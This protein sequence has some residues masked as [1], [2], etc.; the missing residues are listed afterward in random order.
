VLS[1]VTSSVTP[2]R[3]LLCAVPSATSGISE[4]VWRSTKPGVTQHPTTHGEWVKIKKGNETIRAYLAYPERKTK[5]PA[6]I[7]IHEIFGLTEWAQHPASVLPHGHERRLELVVLELRAQD[8]PVP[9]R[10]IA[11]QLGVSLGTV[12]DIERGAGRWTKRPKKAEG[13]SPE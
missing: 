13:E 10:K 6:V 4:W 12:Q 3:T 11:A 8:P 7:V 1:P 9:Y 5:A 2:W